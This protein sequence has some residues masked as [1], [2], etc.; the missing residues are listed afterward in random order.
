MWV[1]VRTR[2]PRRGEGEAVGGRC[3]ALAPVLSGGGCGASGPGGGGDDPWFPGTAGC[4]SPAG[5]AL[6]AAEGRGSV[7]PAA[8]HRVGRGR[9][10][11]GKTRGKGSAGGCEVPSASGAVR[12]WSEYHAQWILSGRKKN[13]YSFK[14]GGRLHLGSEIEVHESI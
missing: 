14:C 8:G 10:S 6:A 9:V 2:R 3:R 12:V 7:A 1:G 4:S 5:P 13:V 11:E